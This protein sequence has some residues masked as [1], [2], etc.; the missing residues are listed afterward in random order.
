MKI[1][2]R[3]R[4]PRRT[5][6]AA[7]AVV[8]LVLTGC[9]P[10]D[11]GTG[12]GGGQAS[13]PGAVMPSAPADLERFYTQEL[14]WSSCEGS[15]DCASVEVPLDYSRPEAETIELAVI[16][17][18]AAKPQGSLLVNPGGPG[19]SGV[20]TVRDAGTLMFSSALREG[21]HLV[22][23]DPRG[24]SR[25][26][27]VTCRTDAE[28]DA[29]RATLFSDSEEDQ[30]RV[31]EYL[32]EFAAQCEERTGL[33]LAFVDTVSAARDLDIL[34]AVNGDAKLNYLGYSYGTR[35]GAAYAGLFPENVGRMVLDGAMDP[36]LTMEETTL[37]QAEAMESS[38]RAYLAEC[39]RSAECPFS[40]DVDDAVEQLHELMRDVDSRPLTTG[41]GRVFNVGELVS[42][43]LM[44]F[45]D[46]GWWPTLTSALAGLFGGD[47]DPLM[48]LADTSAGRNED[49]SYTGNAA[50]AF[51]GVNCL[52]YP[53]TTDEEGMD[54]D[55]EELMEASPTFG[56]FL[57]YGGAVCAHWPFPSTGQ[58]APVEAPGA[59]PIVVIGTTGDPATP[60][61]WAVALSGQLASGVLVSY[62]GHGHTAYGRSNQCIERAVDRY[63]L[64]GTVPEDGLAC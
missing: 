43:V 64:D 49:G 33:P 12:Q 14:E 20:D 28:R 60:Y 38:L 7:A 23:F 1:P 30:R 44:A 2:S 63:F 35:L 16:R 10:L 36:S 52:D 42:G 18:R 32:A 8:A 37:G 17:K 34:R 13:Q 54:A 24:V 53:M 6:V 4:T 22:G 3:F 21:F 11:P 58:P 50:A 5:T 46:E 29:D 40:G 25:S 59:A 19:A 55:A 48:A 56:E 9:V 15:F 47:P 41:D 27:P 39:L 57:A 26:A 61:D 31:E 45:Y 51:Y 62:E